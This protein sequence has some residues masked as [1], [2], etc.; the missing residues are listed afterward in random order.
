MGIETVPLSGG[1]K[2]VVCTGVGI[3]L[4]RLASLRGMLKLESLGMKTRGG[5]LRPRIAKELGL[6]ARAPHIQ[7][8]AEIERRIELAK[9]ELL[10]EAEDK[11]AAETLAAL[12]KAAEK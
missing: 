12:R 7:F 4:F 3:D 10:K 11:A 8:V 5:A 1:G 6:P 9:A 2:V